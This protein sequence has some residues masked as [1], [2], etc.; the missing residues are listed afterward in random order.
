[1]REKA[2]VSWSPLWE[3]GFS[4]EKMPFCMGRFCVTGDICRAVIDPSDRIS[5]QVR[6]NSG[7]RQQGS[8]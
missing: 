7:A 6:P 4:A 8:A 3:E 2:R 5:S 1:M